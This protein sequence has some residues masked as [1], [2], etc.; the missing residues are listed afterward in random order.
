MGKSGNTK[1]NYKFNLNS[2]IFRLTQFI[3]HF[4]KC[5]DIFVKVKLFA[6]VVAVVSNLHNETL[7]DYLGKLGGV[8]TGFI[9]KQP[10]LFV[11]LSLVVFCLILLATRSVES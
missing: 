9:Y 7:A 11:C 2:F 1:Y 8:C 6:V 5:V 10:G 4:H 3:G